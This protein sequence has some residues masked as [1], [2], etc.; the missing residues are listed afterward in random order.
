MEAK[1]ILRNC[2][3]PPR[4]ARLVADLIRG[5]EA[6]KALYILKHHTQSSSYNIEKLLRSAISNWQAANPEQ[7]IE[8]AKLYVKTIFV[9]G[10][11]MIKRIKPA[12]QGRMHRI[13]KRSNHITLILDSKNSAE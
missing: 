2:P 5:M 3:V 10:G 8:D 1:A 6:E 13:R 4:K 7:R 9:D 12:P 11:R